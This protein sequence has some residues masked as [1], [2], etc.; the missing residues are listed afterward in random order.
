MNSINSINNNI[1]YCRPYVNDDPFKY[2]YFVDSEST[3]YIELGTLEYPYKNL[4]YPYKEIFNFMYEKATDVVI[5]LKRN[6][7]YKIHHVN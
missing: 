5:Y 6:T 2:Q 4:D 7:T 3:R 1:G